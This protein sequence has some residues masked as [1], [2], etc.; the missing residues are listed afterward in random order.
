MPKVNPT[1]SNRRIEGK[2]RAELEIVAARRTELKTTPC[3]RSAFTQPHCRIDIDRGHGWHR[4]VAPAP[5]ANSLRKLFDQFRRQR[6]T[7]SASSWMGEPVLGL[8]P[9]RLHSLSP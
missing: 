9:L 3:E 7:I 6:R 2:Q 8:D 4:I 5:R 1:P